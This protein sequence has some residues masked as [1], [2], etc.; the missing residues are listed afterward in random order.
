MQTIGDVAQTYDIT[1]DALRYYEK[2]GLLPPIQRD[3]QGRRLYSDSDLDT[4]NK[5]IHLRKVGA[6]T[7]ECCQLLAAFQTGTSADTYDA[8]LALLNR[9][10]QDLSQRLVQ[11]K[12]Q[13]QFLV[14]KR[15]H[16]EQER[17]RLTQN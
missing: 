6:S 2:I 17:A 11:I 4:L 13:Q 9:L 1:Y 15:A 10:E 8:G 16:I 3:N 5:I 14:K 12:Q 7:A